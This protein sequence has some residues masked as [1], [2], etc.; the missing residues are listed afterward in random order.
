[1]DIADIAGFEQETAAFND[2]DG[3]GGAEHAK[4][5]AGSGPEPGGDT[6]GG[7]DLDL[8][9]PEADVAE[10]RAEAVPDAEEEAAQAGENPAE[11]DMEV[12]PADAAEQRRPVALDDDD[13]R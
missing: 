7:T 2:A 12:D 13:Y 9:A 1:M 8:E 6:G 5:A 3:A 4:D 10:Q 11:D